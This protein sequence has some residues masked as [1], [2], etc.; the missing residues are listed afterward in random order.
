MRKSK[1][2]KCLLW[3][4]AL[5]GDVGEDELLPARLWTGTYKPGDEGEDEATL[6]VIGADIIGRQ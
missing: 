5:V 1:G 3:G 6:I 4:N 2:E